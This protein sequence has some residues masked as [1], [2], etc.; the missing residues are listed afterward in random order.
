MKL[1]TYL[2]DNTP[3]LGL[4]RGEEVVALSSIA[5]DLLTLIAAGPEALARVRDYAATAPPALAL[6]DALSLIHI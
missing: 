4:L 1:L 3:T 6:S 5:P 2:H